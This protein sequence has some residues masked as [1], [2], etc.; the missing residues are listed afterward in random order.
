MLGQLPLHPMMVHFAIVFLI[1]TAVLQL[2]AIF[3][4]RI[5][6]WLGWVLPAAGVMTAVVARI[7]ESLGEVLEKAKP[8]T[9]A[10]HEH[11]EWGEKAGLAALLLGVL[12]IGYWLCTSPRVRGWV[13][14][15]TAFLRGKAMVMIVTVLTAAVCA[16]AIVVTVLAGHSGSVSVWTK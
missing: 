15:R 9:A 11:A 4:P 1:A 6:D 10:I 5:R 13:E 14:R 2:L 3:M 12:T 8:R 7:T 16:L